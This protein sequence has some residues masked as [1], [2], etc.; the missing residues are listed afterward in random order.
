[1]NSVEQRKWKA[2]YQGMMAS[3]ETR[4]RRIWRRL[5]RDPAALKRVQNVLI[6][7]LVLWS[8]LSVSQLLWIPWRGS[9]IESAPALALNPPQLSTQIE[10]VAVDTSAV[11]GSG[12]FG[13]IPDE[14]DASP[15]VNERS[16]NRD[17]IE[18]NATETRLPLT[19]TGIVASTEDGLGS[20]VIRVSGAEQV[21]AVGDSLP[22]SGQV[23]LAKVMPHT[24]V[25]DN[26]GTYELLTL[27][28]GAGLIVPTAPS[29]DAR[30]TPSEQAVTAPRSERRA[31]VVNATAQSEVASR[32]RRTLYENPEALSRLL[33][34]SPVQ[35]DGRITGYRISPNKE[36]AD[37]DALGFKTGD[38]V[39]GVN[40]LSLSDASNTMKLYTLMKEATAA[41]FDIAREGGNVTISVDLANP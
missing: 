8:L 32:Y 37:F 33:T 22:A 20:A 12:V 26:N 34:V 24:I 36:R 28:E 39:I 25:I 2:Q 35:A 16:H 9:A 5:A 29:R 18:R 27:Y 11:I 15:E 14:L 41:T 7:L 30:A 6:V 10:S 4:V 19:L 1:V 38:V 23:T 17:G 31:P 40:G 21:Y 13:G 3:V